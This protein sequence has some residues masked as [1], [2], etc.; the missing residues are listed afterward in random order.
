MVFVRVILSHPSFSS[1]YPTF[2]NNSCD[3]ASSLT[4]LAPT[5]PYTVLQYTDDMLIII[6]ASNNAAQN[7][8]KILDGFA[9]DTVLTINFEKTTLISLNFSPDHAASLEGQL[10]TSIVL[11]LLNNLASP[12]A[13]QAAL[14][15]L[16]TG[17]Y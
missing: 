15:R 9:L 4:L 3:M 2:C 1:L 5:L 16:P 10:D 11:F 6:K 17:H 13:P 12:L 8:R 14:Q 7:L